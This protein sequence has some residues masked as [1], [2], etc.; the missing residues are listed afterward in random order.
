MRV[1]PVSDEL[2]ALAVGSGA[3]VA[4]SLLWEGWIELR[5]IPQQSCGAPGL[6]LRSVLFNLLQQHPIFEE[7][8]GVGIAH[9]FGDNQLIA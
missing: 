1:Q 7:P 6:F 2:P 9:L 5:G 3:L 8:E 4:H